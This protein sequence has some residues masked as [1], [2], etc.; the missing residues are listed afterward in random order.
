M[1][2]LDPQIASD[3]FFALDNYTAFSPRNVPADQLADSKRMT[4]AYMKIFRSAS[5]EGGVYSVFRESYQA[6]PSLGQY[7]AEMAKF[8]PQLTRVQDDTE[9]LMI[10]YL[11][12]AVPSLQQVTWKGLKAQDPA[13]TR[14]QLNQ[15][16]AT[17]QQALELFGQG[18]LFDKRRNN[19]EYGYWSIH[20]M[21]STYPENP[22]IGYYSWYVFVRAYSKVTGRADK[23]LLHF[24]RC[25]ALAAAIQNKLEPKGASGP[26]RRNPNNKP[27]TP[28]VL[29]RLQGQYMTKKFAELDKLFGDAAR[30]SPLGP[31]PPTPR[32]R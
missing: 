32:F 7:K 3:F 9:R 4:A 27:I 12:Q 20:S 10:L 23:S 11:G 25:I 28:A 16:S 15:L 19:E 1:S 2:S 18:V 31:P 21:D 29:K 13:K 8:E 17:I 5:G 22:P 24:A 26:T 6:D 30:N 14:R